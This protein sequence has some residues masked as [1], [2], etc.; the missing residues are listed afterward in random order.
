M[1]SITG[2]IMTAERTVRAGYLVAENL[3]KAFLGWQKDVQ[4]AEDEAVVIGVKTRKNAE[5]PYLFPVD[6]GVCFF[7][8]LTLLI[9]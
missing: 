8:F 9:N 7:L 3:M 1:E 5:F 4:K 2:N 6:V